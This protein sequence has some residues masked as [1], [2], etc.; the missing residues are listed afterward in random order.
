MVAEWKIPEGPFKSIYEVEEFKN[1][2]EPIDLYNERYVKDASL[3]CQAEI[4]DPHR[5]MDEVFSSFDDDSSVLIFGAGHSYNINEFNKHPNVC[6]TASWDFVDAASIGLNDGI[7]FYN[8][9]IMEDTIDAEYDYVFTSH[10]LEHFTSKELLTVVLPRL[11]LLARKA[12]AIVVPYAKS[13][14]GEPRHKCRFYENDEMA[15]IS[16]RYKIIRG[17]AEIVYWVDMIPNVYE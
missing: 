8:E 5:Y 10:T 1:T 11:F 12:V 16:N 2:A 3:L 14:E 9:N 4:D 17:G 13:W 15:L 7:R 6:T